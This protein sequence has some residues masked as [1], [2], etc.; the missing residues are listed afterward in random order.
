MGHAGRK[1]TP[2]LIYG[3]AINDAEYITQSRNGSCPIY[4]RWKYMLDRCYSPRESSFG[5]AFITNEWLR[6]S[7]F[8]AWMSGQNWVGLELDKDILI[9]G[10]RI[11]S[12]EACCFVPQYLNNL[13]NCVKPRSNPDYLIGTRMGRRGRYE[14]KCSAGGPET[15][16]L[17]SFDSM[18]LAHKAWQEQKIIQIELSVLRYSKESYFRAD[19][20]DALIERAHGIRS[21]IT[22]GEPTYVI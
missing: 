3:V 1:A 18:E 6:F 9:P 10:N 7:F 14:A 20:A 19:V 2:K 13:L 5:K 22:A 16:H 15:I 21:K 4:M 11:Y 8:H 17:G 12:A